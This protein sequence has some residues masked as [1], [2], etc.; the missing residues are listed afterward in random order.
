MR[1]IWWWWGVG[2]SWG[3]GFPNARGKSSMEDCYLIYASIGRFI[4]L[5]NMMSPILI[6][7]VRMNT[8]LCW[9]MSPILGNRPLLLVLAARLIVSY[10]DTDSYLCSILTYQSYYLVKV[11]FVIL[12]K[13]ILSAVVPPHLEVVV[14]SL[15]PRKTEVLDA[16][17]GDVLVN[18]HLTAR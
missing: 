18:S 14:P 9:M 17:S 2:L 6:F 5:I 11:I 8:K 4:Q 10:T 12:W 13:H 15:V 3:G 16:F 1:L 7:R